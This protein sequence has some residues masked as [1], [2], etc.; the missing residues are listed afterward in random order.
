M[1]GLGNVL[2]RKLFVV[3]SSKQQAWKTV[4][5]LPIPSMTLTAKA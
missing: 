4:P 2:I 3:V 1:G 5:T